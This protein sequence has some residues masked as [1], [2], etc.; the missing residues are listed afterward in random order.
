MRQFLL[1][2][3]IDRVCNLMMPCLQ[4]YDFKQLRNLQ[5]VIRLLMVQL[6]GVLPPLVWLWHCNSAYAYMLNS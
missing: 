6:L 2:I 1:G 3:G 4:D 5:Y